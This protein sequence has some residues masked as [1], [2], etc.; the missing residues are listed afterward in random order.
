MNPFDSPAVVR[1]FTS[2]APNPSLLAFADAELARIHRGRVLDI[3]CGAARNAVP[4]AAL[5]WSVLGVDLSLPMLAAA[6]ER[7]R[8]A[9]VERSCRFVLARMDR[10]PVPDRS[11]DL[12]VAHGIW[13]LARSAGEFRAALREAARAAKPGAA[14][15]VFT[16]SR[17]T[18]DD[19]AQPIANESFV[20]TQFSGEPHVFLTRDQLLDELSAVGF[21]PDPVVPLRELNRRTPGMLAA[22]GSPVIWEG[23]FRFTAPRPT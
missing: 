13:N 10:L 12:L 11:C 20:F 17:N 9:E 3:G 19:S 14:L 7:A 16:F 18:L 8:A 21:A 2:G 5:G 22:A 4:L 1:G 23:A 15:F 6:E